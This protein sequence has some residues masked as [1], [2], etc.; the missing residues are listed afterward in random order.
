LIPRFYQIILESSNRYRIDE[1]M[2]PLERFHLTDGE[3][4]VIGVIFKKP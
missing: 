2:D 3:R 1:E 4:R